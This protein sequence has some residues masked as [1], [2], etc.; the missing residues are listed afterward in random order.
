MQVAAAVDLVEQALALDPRGSRDRRGGQQGGCDVDEAGDGGDSFAGAA[1][2]RKSQQE[3]YAGGGVVEEKAVVTLAM[4]SERFAVIGGDDEQGPLAGA[5]RVPQPFDQ[6]VDVGDLTVVGAVGKAFLPGCRQ[7]EWPV[8]V[9]EMDKSKERFRVGP[10]KPLFGGGL[11]RITADLDHAGIIARVTV[12]IKATPVLVKTAAQAEAPVK[13][14]RSYKR[15]CVVLGRLEGLR[16]GRYAGAQLLAVVMYA[17]GSGIKAG[18]QGG[19][20]RQSQRHGREDP[21]KDHAFASEAVEGG[22]H[23]RSIAVTAEVVGAQGID[24]DE[25]YIPSLAGVERG[26][27]QRTKNR[28]T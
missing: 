19:M 22:G 17:V 28:G 4:V 15:G 16:Q 14:E 11:D 9:I 21:V 7:E 3:R 8:Q 6:A 13:N 18:K 10:A 2:I 12:E 23:R 20:R 5:H 25:K 1:G 24:R 26:R 27:L